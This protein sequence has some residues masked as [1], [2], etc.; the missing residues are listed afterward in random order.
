[1]AFDPQEQLANITVVASETARLTRAL[2]GWPAAYWRR[3]TYCPGWQAIDA[4]AHLATGGEFY[5]Q[6]IAAGRGGTPQLPW[7]TSDAAGARAARVAA[8]KELVDAGPAVALAGFTQSAAKLQAVFQSLQED[9]LARVAWH[10]RGLVP[11]GCWVGMRLNEL[12]IH[13]WDMRQPHEAN[14]VLSLMAVPA[15]LTILPELQA[16]FLEQRLP[17]GLDGTHA[18]RAGNA[19]WAFTIRGKTVTYQAQAPTRFDTSLCAD[20]DS[21]ILLTMGRADMQ[22]KLH[23]GALTLTGDPDKAQRLCTTLFRAF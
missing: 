11:I 3:P 7:G 20:A 13:D 2:Q 5:A 1:M 15:M 4:V 9:D 18:I 17:D 21:L 12:V 22:A 6:V 23:S 10:P 8:S 19:T 14:A 16:Q